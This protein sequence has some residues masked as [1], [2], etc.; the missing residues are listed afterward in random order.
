MLCLH[1]YARRQAGVRK[2]RGAK[3]LR[4]S[5]RRKAG[6]LVRCQFSHAACGRDAFYWFRRLGFTR[7]SWRAGENLAMGTG[8]LGTARA[9]MSGWLRSPTH[10][11]VL[12]SPSF[13]QV[14][15]AL[16]RGAYEGNP[17]A[18]YWVAHFGYRR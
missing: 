14:G 17:N 2:L 15:I 6:D 1:R 3:V 7:G 4:R 13:R 9:N 8:Q 5:A 12:L 18:Q 10:R 11:R 16:A